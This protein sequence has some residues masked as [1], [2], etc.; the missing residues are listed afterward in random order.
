MHILH[1]FILLTIK[2]LLKYT[3]YFYFLHLKHNSFIFTKIGQLDAIFMQCSICSRYYECWKFD[4]ILE[5]SNFQQ[6]GNM[7]AADSF[8]TNRNSATSLQ[9]RDQS[10]KQRLSEGSRRYYNH[11]EGP[12]QDLLLDESSYY[13]LILRHYAKWTLTLLCECETS[14]NL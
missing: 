11:K 3:F 7:T 5:C 13:S 10:L 1:K 6:N 2:L 9:H 14:H 4:L 8:F 12:Y